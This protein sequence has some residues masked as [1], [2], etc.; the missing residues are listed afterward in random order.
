MAVAHTLDV[1]G[2]VQTDGP[3]ADSVHGLG[4]EEVMRPRWRRRGQMRAE[5]GNKNTKGANC[6]SIYKN[7]KAFPSLSV[8]TRNYVKVI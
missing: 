7:S 3:V 6:G 5:S 8:T 2:K 4:I 1:G